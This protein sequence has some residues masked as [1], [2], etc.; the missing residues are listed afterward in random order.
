[1]TFAINSD[2]VALHPVRLIRWL[3][4]STRRNQSAMAARTQLV[5]CPK[6]LMKNGT[7]SYSGK[8]VRS[9]HARR[10]DQ[11]EVAGFDKSAK[12]LAKDA[13]TATSKRYERMPK[14]GQAF[15]VDDAPQAQAKKPA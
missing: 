8:Q 10:R 9:L 2:P 14:V 15:V 13:E 5:G 12:Q 1:M 7:R 3:G 11:D 6:V 4:H